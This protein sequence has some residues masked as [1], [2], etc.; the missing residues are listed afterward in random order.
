MLR[1]VA[2]DDARAELSVD[3]DTICREGARRMVVAALRP[4]AT[5]IW[6]RSRT[7]ETMT[8]AV[9][10]WAMAGLGLG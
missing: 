7:S 8:A 10:W 5:P 9:W 2:D 4:S 3:L 1:V 6:P